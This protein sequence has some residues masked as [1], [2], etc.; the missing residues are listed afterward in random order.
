TMLAARFVQAIGVCAGTAIAR[1]IVRDLF[2]GARAAQVM[3]ALGM[4][5]T[6]A[7]A[8][9]PVLGGHLESW[10]NWRA[11]FL[12]QALFGLTIAAVTVTVLPGTNRRLDVRALDLARMSRNYRQLAGNRIF[13][14]YSVLNACLLGGM[15]TFAAVGPFV[16]ISMI[17]LTP[18]LYGWLML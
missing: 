1:A 7:P 2:G 14:G 17:G 8:V 10:F 3:A 16:F 11:I 4:A 13:M 12:F 6:V 18:E 9:G 5:L 15:F